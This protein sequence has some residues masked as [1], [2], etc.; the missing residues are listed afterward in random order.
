M[1]KL[2]G[3]VVVAVVL[4]LGFDSLQGWYKGEATPQQAVNEV[5][6]KVGEKL[7]GDNPSSPQ[8]PPPNAKQEKQNTTP[9]QSD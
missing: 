1:F 3:I 6:K 5:R 9:E 7:V 2:I 8:Q 4:Y